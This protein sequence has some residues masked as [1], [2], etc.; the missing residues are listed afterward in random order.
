MIGRQFAGQ[1]KSEAGQLESLLKG[2]TG[3]EKWE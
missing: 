2:M 1:Q 3:S